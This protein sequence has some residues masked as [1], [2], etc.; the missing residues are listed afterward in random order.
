M[1]SDAQIGMYS[2]VQLHSSTSV[3]AEY[4]DCI[5]KAEIPMITINLIRPIFY[6]FFYKL[7]ELNLFCLLF[8]VIAYNFLLELIYSYFV[9]LFKRLDKNNA[10]KILIA[11]NSSV[12]C[13]SS[14]TDD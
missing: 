3:G 5:A 7:F 8:Q 14:A 11:T 10:T 6:T 4:V 12:L 9:C 1:L 2:R 13:H